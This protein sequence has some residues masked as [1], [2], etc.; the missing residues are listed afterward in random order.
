MSFENWMKEAEEDMNKREKKDL[1]KSKGLIA[2]NYHDRL[3][4]YW[5][6]YKTIQSTKKLIW[7]T[8]SLAI[9]TIFLS[10]LTLYLQYFKK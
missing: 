3:I 9:A 2:V 7:A 6:G 4:S 10:G 5:I 1:K 8:W